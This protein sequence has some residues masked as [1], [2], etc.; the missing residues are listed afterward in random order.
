MKFCSLGRNLPPNFMNNWEDSPH[1]CKGVNLSTG[2]GVSLE[3]ML[4]VILCI[5][6]TVRCWDTGACCSHIPPESFVGSIGT[7]LGLLARKQQEK[8]LSLY[9]ARCLALGVR[10]SSHGSLKSS[11]T[12]CDKPKQDVSSQC[13]QYRQPEISWSPT[14]KLVHLSSWEEIA[15]G[16]ARLWWHHKLCTQIVSELHVRIPSNTE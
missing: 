5:P 16:H 13:W 7:I 4:P 8:I 2:C 9:F 14:R 1:E 12:F 10:W 3:V 6:V 11:G 15:W